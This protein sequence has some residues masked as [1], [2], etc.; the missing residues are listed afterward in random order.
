[1]LRRK[2]GEMATYAQSR[3]INTLLQKCRERGIEIPEEVKERVSNELT[4]EEASELIEA[5]KFELG[6]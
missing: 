5:L 6:W 4:A 1:M 2:G 3:Y